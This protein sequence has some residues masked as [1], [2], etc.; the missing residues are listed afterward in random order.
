MKRQLSI[1]ISL[2]IILCGLNANAFGKKNN[3]VKKA[4]VGNL[5]KQEKIVK[6]KVSKE[7]K[8]TKAKTSKQEKTSEEQ[9]DKKIASQAKKAEK[10]NLK[11]AKKEAKNEKKSEKL[12]KKD[13]KTEKNIEKNVM[14]PSQNPILNPET[15]YYASMKKHFLNP[16]LDVTEVRAKHILVRKRADALSIRKDILSGQISFEEAA[17]RFSLC[18]TGQIGG[19]LGFFNRKKME[20]V[21]ADT[22]FD[23]NINEISQPVGTKFGW[24]LIKTIDK[25]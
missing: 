24:H 13:K 5:Q 11:K 9:I 12:A 3:N 19:D 25:R 16:N 8:V 20:Q 2:A 15:T 4:P 17:M 6:T 21:F 10:E 7:E 1:L 18:P 14:L 22:A 23:L